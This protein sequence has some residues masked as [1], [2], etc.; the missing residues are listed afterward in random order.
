MPNANQTQEATAADYAP[1]PAEIAAEESSNRVG[2]AAWLAGFSALFGF[3]TFSKVTTIGSGIA[4][5]GVAAMV[6]VVCC[7]ILRS[8]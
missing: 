4:F 2:T 3:M 5:A 7:F 8:K 6:T 1:T